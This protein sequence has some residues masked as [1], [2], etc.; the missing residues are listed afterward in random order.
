[1]KEGAAIAERLG[2]PKPRLAEQFASEWTKMLGECSPEYLAKIEKD[3][4]DLGEPDLSYIFAKHNA[5]KILK[6][7]D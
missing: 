3:Q 6:T 1:V 5:Q 4:G 2:L 7:L